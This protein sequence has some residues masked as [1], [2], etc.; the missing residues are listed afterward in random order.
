MAFALKL[1]KRHGKTISFV[2]SV[3]W[4]IGTVYQTDKN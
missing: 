4:N 1:R 2:I 3:A